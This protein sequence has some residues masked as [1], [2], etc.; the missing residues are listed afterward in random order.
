MNKSSCIEMIGKT[1]GEWEVLSR[2]NNYN[3]HLV[4]YWC[5]CKCGK[6]KSVAGSELRRGRSKSCGGHREKYKERDHILY[7][8]WNGMKCRCKHEEKYENISVC[9]EWLGKDGYVNF[10]K[11]AFAN[12]YKPE[13]TLDRIDTL[14]NYEPSNCRWV[15][16]DIQNKNKR[17][18][19]Y[20][21]K[22]G[23]VHCR[24][25]WAR[26]LGVSIYKMRYWLNKTGVVNGM[27]FNEVEY[28]G[29]YV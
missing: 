20:Y 12:G 25:E 27:K 24:N 1:F 17:N 29:G 7:T 8:K 26:I 23:E 28:K 2:D 14:G 4:H 11:W 18:I 21:E 3:S 19:R 16:F 10:H 13:L 6:V 22:D 5:K 15:S 9:D